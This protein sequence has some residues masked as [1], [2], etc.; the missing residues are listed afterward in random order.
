VPGTPGGKA[1]RVLIGYEVNWIIFNGRWYL[2]SPMPL[3]GEF[4]LTIPGERTSVILDRVQMRR[5][6]KESLGLPGKSRTQ[7]NKLR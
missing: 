2:I 5:A 6:V 1:F 7:S 3:N 4:R